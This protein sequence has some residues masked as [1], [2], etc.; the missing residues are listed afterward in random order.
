MGS[1]YTAKCK[2]MLEVMWG[3][4]PGTGQEAGV[5]DTWLMHAHKVLLPGFFRK[6][7]KT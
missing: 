6:N 2:W 5:V 1:L 4:D 3:K 7:S